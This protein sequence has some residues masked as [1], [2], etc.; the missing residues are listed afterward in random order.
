MG[1]YYEVDISGLS[2]DRKQA[3]YDVLEKSAFIFE[4]AAWGWRFNAFH[5]LPYGEPSIDE[6]RQR[7]Q[8]PDS[9]LVRPY[10][11]PR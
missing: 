8:I 5:F 1:T 2:V 7:Y 4:E 6:L 10:V 3:L 11:H 9:C